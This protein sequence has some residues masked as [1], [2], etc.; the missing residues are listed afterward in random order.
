M[1]SRR[2][3]SR[4]IAAPTGTE[5]SCR[6]WTTEAAMRML[7]NNLDPGV[8]EAP[9]S[10]AAV[11]AQTGG[12]I[13]GSVNDDQGLAMPGVE[14]T[15]RNAE[16]GLTRSTVSEANGTY[17]FPF[18]PA[19]TYVVGFTDLDGTYVNEY[20]DDQLS[21]FDADPVTVTAGGVT[22]AIDAELALG[23]HLS[24]TG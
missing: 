2:D 1:H 7:M 12:A 22:P 11:G 4:H 15:L 24:G 13:L 23:G 5:L 6:S 17:R 8:A 21:I 3:N 19:G 18:T 20:Y 16:N 14:L 9:E 10:A